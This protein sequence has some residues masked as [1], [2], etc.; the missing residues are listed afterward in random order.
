[1]ATRRIQDLENVE[2]VL[3][4]S[5]I[6]VGEATKTKSMLVSQLKNWLAS[7]FVGK[8]GN[9][10]IRGQKT[11]RD[12]PVCY[13]SSGVKLL[14]RSPTLDID[15]STEA[16]NQLWFMD[17]NQVLYAVLQANKAS[18]GRLQIS[19][20]GKAKSDGSYTGFVI[21]Q[22]TNGT[23][24]IE[25][26]A[27]ADSDNSTKVVNSGW[28]NRNLKNIL[29]PNVGSLVNIVSAVSTSAG[30]TA[31]SSGF[32][33]VQTN[34]NGATTTLSVGG[35]VVAQVEQ[36]S[37]DSHGGE[38]KQLFALVGKGQVIKTNQVV[39]YGVFVP[40]K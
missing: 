15:S 12:I 1:M 4:D 20:L 13:T 29:T 3:A 18:D 30:Y 9:E 27:P 23:T 28:V 31:P 17:K 10:D 5:I 14:L 37:G 7:F 8:T 24:Y 36:Y 21:N 35:Q 39:K 26:P 22:Q 6:P 34:V 38:T 32:V 33:S 19:L 40:F 11:F 25:V 2:E 16:Q